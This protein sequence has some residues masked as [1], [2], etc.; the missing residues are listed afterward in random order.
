MT[1]LLLCR[2]GQ[3]L[4]NAANRIQGQH[5]I[6]LDDL[7]RAQAEQAATLLADERPDAL[8]ASDLR[9]A[10]DTAAAIGA[11]TGL[12]ARADPRLREIA[13]GDW[14]G[15]TGDEVEAR[16]PEEYLRWKSG[17][18]VRVS[19]VEDLNQVVKRMVEGLSA[20][21]DLAPDGT[22]VVVGHGGSAKRGC[23][24]L[25]GWSEDMV[26]TIR[27]MSNCH[28]MDLRRGRTGWRMYGYNLGGR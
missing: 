15:L 27:G 26:R 9:R 14:E 18:Q 5:D 13:Y 2:H 17:Q 24:G 25:L 6:D 1:R 16:Y 11:A 7:G 3:T 28:W 10:W 21:A 19:G 4:W 20:A 22:V 23:A 8:V 12:S